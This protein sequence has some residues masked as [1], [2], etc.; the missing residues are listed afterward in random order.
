MILMNL[1]LKPDFL[2]AHLTLIDE[3]NRLKMNLF[4]KNKFQK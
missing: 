4:L 1:E 2:G 3:G